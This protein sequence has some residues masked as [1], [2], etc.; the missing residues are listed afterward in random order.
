M[1]VAELI[2]RLAAMPADVPVKVYELDGDFWD[3]IA[4]VNM[5]H[6]R[7]EVRIEG[8]FGQNIA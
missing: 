4:S 2:K 6:A 7:I 8:K 3:D 5:D 1:T